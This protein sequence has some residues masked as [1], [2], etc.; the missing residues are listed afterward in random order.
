MIHIIPYQVVKA[1]QVK[2]LTIMFG[3]SV[4]WQFAKGFHLPGIKDNFTS[5]KIFQPQDYNVSRPKMLSANGR[6]FYISLGVRM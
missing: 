6:T 1:L 4:N 3:W 2:Y 5:E